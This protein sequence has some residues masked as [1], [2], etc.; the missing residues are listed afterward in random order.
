MNKL[1]IGNIPYKATSEELRTLCE[2][3]GKVMNISVP[4]DRET[5][6]SKG[7]AFVEFS[8]AAEARAARDGLDTTTFG[9][10]QIRVDFA[11]SKERGR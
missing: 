3:F 1:F 4:T 10:R 8:T 9:G 2:P 6:N 5:G 7:F 11:K